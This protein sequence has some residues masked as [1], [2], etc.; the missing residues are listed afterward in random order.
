MSDDTMIIRTQLIGPN[1]CTALGVE[2]K[3]N[4]PVL[5]LCRKLLAAGHDPA[6]VLEA[7]RSGTLC[8]RVRS[9]GEGAR[10]RIATHGVGFERMPECTG[11]P[12]ARQNAIKLSDP[13]KRGR[14]DDSGRT[15]A[16]TGFFR[17]HPAKI[18]RHRTRRS[19]ATKTR[20]AR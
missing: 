14:R 18:Y 9:I 5:D 7:Y 15:A 2:A 8:L 3:G 17:T 16:P 20:R 10:L 13:P 1:R 11:G 12:P 19:P 6:L 4:A